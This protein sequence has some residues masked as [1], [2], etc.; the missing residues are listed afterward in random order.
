MQDT[1]TSKHQSLWVGAGNVHNGRPW[2]ICRQ[3]AH[4]SAC[5]V[6]ILDRAFGARNQSS[7]SAPSCLFSRQVLPAA[8]V[9]NACR[10]LHPLSAALPRAST[11]DINVD[12]Q[13][14]VRMDIHK[15]VHVEASM[16]VHMGVNMGVHMD[17]HSLTMK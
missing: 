3:R 8:T 13:M 15:D 14:E 6:D 17:I 5:P 1:K 10:R 7:L 12:I 4:P 11:V 2:H 9:H 16:D